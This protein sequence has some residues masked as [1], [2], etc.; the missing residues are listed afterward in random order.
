MMIG[1]ELAFS[2]SLILAFSYYLID[3][4][5]SYGYLLNQSEFF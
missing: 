3:T 1:Y 2:N 5:T 4:F